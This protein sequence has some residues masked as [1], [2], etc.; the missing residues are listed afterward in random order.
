MASVKIRKSSCGICSSQ[1]PLD[2]RVQDGKIRSVE[3]GKNNPFQ[4]GG[5]CSKGAASRQYVYNKERI[6]YPMKRVGKK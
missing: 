2:I 3:G 4:Y 6:L 5:I 1:C